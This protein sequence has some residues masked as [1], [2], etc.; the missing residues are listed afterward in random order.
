MFVNKT[1]PPAA[2][3]FNAGVVPLPVKFI[4]VVKPPPPKAPDDRLTVAPSNVKVSSTV[5]VDPG[6]C[7]KFAPSVRLLNAV[8]LDCATVTPTPARL[9]LVTV[10]PVIV[11]PV[12]RFNAPTCPV[13][14]R[15]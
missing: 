5:T 1:V 12:N 14:A 4:L 13:A 3:A 9:L 10:P 15:S 2:V 8:E 7:V 11:E 6:L